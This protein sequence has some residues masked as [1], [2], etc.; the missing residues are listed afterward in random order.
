MLPKLFLNIRFRIAF[1]VV[2]CLLPAWLVTAYFTVNSY[3][4]HRDRISAGYLNSA[5]GLMQVVERELA[6]VEAS[7]Q[8]LATSSSIDN[9]D[10][11]SFE[12]QMHQVLG[13]LHGINL[14][15]IDLDGQQLVNTA[16]P[17]GTALPKEPLRDF[18]LRVLQT[19]QASTSN[20]FYG[21]VLKKHLVAM[22][23][24]VLRAKKVTAFLSLSMD[25]ENLATLLDLQDYPAGWNASVSDG[26]GNTIAHTRS[27]S[28]VV[29]NKGSADLLG[30]VQKV[31]NG[32]FTTK[33]PDGTELM[34]AYQQSTINGW[35][36]SIAIADNSLA[37]QLTRL[38]W[39]Q[40]A[41][42]AL[43][44]LA[45]LLLAN[46]IGL[47]ISRPIQALVEPALALGQGRPFTIPALNLFEAEAVGQAL[48]LTQ[49]LL[50]QRENE[51]DL[52]RNDAMTDGMTGVANRRRFDQALASEWSRAM[53]SGQPLALAM[54][55]V[56]WFKKYNDHYGHQAG[57]ECLR[58]VARVLM[59]NIRRGG[60][61]VARY[62]GEEFAIIAPA[63]NPDA[64]LRMARTLCEAIQELALPHATSEFGRVSIS[65]GVASFLPAQGET[66]ES[67]VSQA[68]EA[69]YLAKLQG[70]NRAI[71]NPPLPASGIGSGQ[72][73][74][75]LI[76]LLWQEAF[77]TGNTRIDSQHRELFNVANELLAALFSNR[78][79]D[80]I[81]AILSHLFT[82]IARHFQDEEN[83]L[84]QLGFADLERHAAEHRRLLNHAHEIQRAFE[85]QPLQVGALL[86]FLTR[87]VV[88]HHI[89]GSDR[90]YAALTA[91]ASSDM[92][93][94]LQSFGTMPSRKVE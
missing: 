85:A 1:L 34:V 56:D 70:R 94:D 23:V 63:T 40:S 48:L 42:T 46:R 27:T 5:K 61:L 39:L 83:I 92:G 64:A 52:A 9:R 8:S 12:K 75:N 59:N 2:A 55:D 28:E 84:R 11:A 36:Y 25:A 45:G 71:L 29:G 76:E 91:S 53:R 14:L 69:L 80:E 62:G 50:I 81:S 89:L 30:A 51:R 32:I 16:L 22:V 33:A 58:R 90:E 6:V 35:T 65:I 49:S 17:L 68:D 60:D 47:G 72:P 88:A 13:N 10:L 54:I 73:S 77:L 18:M 19:G 3:Q 87:E 24:P 37:D 93:A 4:Q 78:S 38:L 82:D 41:A 26:L 79:T 66:P 31:S 43:L 21:P 86:Q 74:G 7:L 67:L 57:D 44:L 15:L 20:L